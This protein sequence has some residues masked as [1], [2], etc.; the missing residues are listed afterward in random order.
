MDHGP[1]DYMARTRDRYSELGYPAYRWVADDTPPPFTPLSKP[2]GQC[3]VGLIGSGGAYVRGQLAYHFSDDVTYRE[4]PS[5]TDPADI[6][7]THFAYDVRDAR[8]DPNCVLPL[9]PLQT[10]ARFGELGEVAR[11]AFCFVGGIYSSRRC[12]DDLAPRLV[13][14]LLAQECDAA[15]LVPV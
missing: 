1:V 2:L 9:A 8:R 15:L 10:L 6:R 13:E 3:R 12:R 7:I 11:S 4:I 5:D 14:R